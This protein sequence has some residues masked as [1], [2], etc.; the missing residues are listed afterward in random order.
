MN[1]QK[2]PLDPKDSILNISL[3][4]SSGQF[5]FLSKIFLNKFEKVE[6]HGLGEA[7]KTVAA[8]AESLSR[9]QYATI[10]KIETQTY[11]PEQGGKKIKLIAILEITEEGK[12]KIVSELQRKKPEEGK[13]NIQQEVQK[14][15]ENQPQ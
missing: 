8:V 11:T 4:K 13:K 9:N 2:Q 15:V 10:K 7:T 12:K 1:Q 14:Q 6:L 5:I 3:K